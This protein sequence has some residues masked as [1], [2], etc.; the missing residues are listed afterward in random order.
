M[1][2]NTS[3]AMCGQQ[4]SPCDCVSAWEERKGDK[5]ILPRIT[6]LVS[7]L[8]RCLFFFKFVFPLQLPTMLKTY[9]FS[10]LQCL[11]AAFFIFSATRR[12]VKSN[13]K[14]LKCHATSHICED[15][16]AAC[17]VKNTKRLAVNFDLFCLTHPTTRSILVQA[18]WVTRVVSLRVRAHTH[19]HSHTLTQ[20]NS[21]DILTISLSLLGEGLEGEPWSLLHG[22]AE[23]HSRCS[24]REGPHPL[25]LLWGMLCHRARQRYAQFSTIQFKLCSRV[26]DGNI[27][28]SLFAV[29]DKSTIRFIPR[30]NGVHS[31]DVKFNGCHIPGSP[32][33]VRVGD[34]GLIGDPG[35]VTA[36]GAGLQG[37]T[38]G[39]DHHHF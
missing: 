27:S 7:S 12:P 33:N 6:L 15:R 11:L 3:C 26:L 2:V 36:H 5:R 10:P 16:S 39:S 22:A 21:T 20:R 9:S 8:H 4:A 18:W 30:E 13:M 37:G 19:S 35:M 14:R 17:G 28:T 24:R 29:S 34:L 25:W 31:I 23:R 32:F 1:W 38:T